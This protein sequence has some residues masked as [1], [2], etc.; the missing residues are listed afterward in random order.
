LCS[1]FLIVDDTSFFFFL[2]KIAPHYIFIKLHSDINSACGW[3]SSEL[4]Q[5]NTNQTRV[6]SVSRLK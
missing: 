4:S 6:I 1:C 3:C 2:W 5:L